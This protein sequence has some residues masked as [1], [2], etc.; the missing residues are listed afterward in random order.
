[1]VLDRPEPVIDAFLVRKLLGSQFP[2]WAGL[3]IEPVLPGGWDHRSFRLGD[4]MVV[5]LPSAEAYATQVEKEHRWLSI[6]AQGL[7][8]SIPQ[9]I[10]LGEPGHGYPWRW[11]IRGWIEGEIATHARVNDL[12]GFAR[13]VGDFLN[14]LHRV[15]ARGGPPP[16][17]GN[18]FRGGRLAT[19]DEEARRAIRALDGEIDVSAAMQIWE[20]A[21]ATEWQ[22]GPVWVHGDM[23]AGNLLVRDGRL[24]AVIDFGSMAAGDPACDVAIAWTFFSAETR[25][26]LRSALRVDDATWQRG[27]G[28]ALW[29]ASIVA[30]GMA[31]TNAVEEAQA[32][33]TIA[34]I[35]A[36][37]R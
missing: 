18:F 36:E 14:A 20:G 22:R 35:V 15:D 23:S 21:L 33:S 11:A 32:R 6:L 37:G 26:V 8:L 30:A 31:R 1:M 24:A 3:P 13:S 2:R 29:K 9:P 28:W 16:G 5:R 4:G 12:P 34:Q 7:P 19:Y 27:R 10:A 25:P 17:A